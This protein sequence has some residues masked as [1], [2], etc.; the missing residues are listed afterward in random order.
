MQKSHSFTR[1]AALVFPT[2][3]AGSALAARKQNERLSGTAPGD[4]F[5]PGVL[6]E[7]TT[8]I[9]RQAGED[10]HGRTPAGFEAEV[11]QVIAAEPAEQ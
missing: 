7:G 5:S 10:E 8:Y 2:M 11:Q 1:G 4:H 9:P 6:I 3:A